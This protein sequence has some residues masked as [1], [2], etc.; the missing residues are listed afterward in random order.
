MLGRLGMTVEACKNEYIELASKAFVT[1]RLIY[2]PA[3]PNGLYSAEALKNPIITVIQRQC[4][5]T[6]CQNRECIHGEIEFRDPGCTKTVVLAITKDDVDALPTLF[7]TY[8]RSNEFEGCKIWEVAR[9][10]SAALTFFKSIKCGPN[11]VEYIDAGFGY[12]NPTQILLDEARSVFH[13]PDNSNTFVLSIGTGLGDPVTIL[14]SRISIIK[15]MKKMATSSTTIENAMDAQLEP[16]MYYR[17][18]VIKG[19]SRINLAEWSKWSE[20]ATH[21][22][23]YLREP[24][25]GRGIANCITKLDRTT[26]EP[27]LGNPESAGLGA[28]ILTAPSTSEH[29]NRIESTDQCKLGSDGQQLNA[30]NMSQ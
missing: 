26:A 8:D 3:P 13:L 4:N 30:P 19:L 23:N 22:G 18:N 21:T 25:Q 15:S 6:A 27:V 16:N 2:L 7:K 14:D 17:F 12:N 1:K 29:G 11:E 24:K 9:A 20:I 10:T 5:N 28:V